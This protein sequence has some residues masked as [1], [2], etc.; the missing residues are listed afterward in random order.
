MSSVLR[1][2][3]GVDIGGTFT[4]VV[5]LGDDGSVR[6]AKVLS[7]P[8]DYARGVVEGAVACIAD[9][10]VTRRRRSTGVV[11]ASTVASNA[12]LEAAWGA[13]RA[14]DDEGLPR[15]ARD[16]APAHP[17]ALRPPVPEAAAARAAPRCGSRSTSGSARGARS[18]R[19]LDEETVRDGRG[20]DPSRTTSRR[21]RSALLHSYAD[22]AHERRVE[23]IVRAA[24]GD[25]VYVTRSSE[26]LPEIREYERTSTA[27]VNA[28]V[29][30][31]VARYLDSLD[32]P[33][34]RRRHRRTARGH[35]V[36]RR[37]LTPADGARASRRTSSSPAR[38]PA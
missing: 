9:C 16:A 26:I 24:V 5:L 37:Q 3:L 18:G 7:T 31:T 32:R 35:A 10:G 1:Y 8:D 19:A 30:P 12:I 23:E 4:D 25:R 15:R 38:R 21:S 34:A 20:A 6:T 2:R 11:H 28:Y 29:G 13:D 33:S 17:G 22:D 27:V 14:R 36:E